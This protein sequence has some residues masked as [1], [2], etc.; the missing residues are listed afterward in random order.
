M[1]HIDLQAR[2]RQ[3]MIDAGFAPS[4]SDAAREQV[5]SLQSR[6]APTTETPDPRDL[7]SI[8][9]SS[10]DNED[11]KDFDQL[12]FAQMKDGGAL[13]I[14][15]AIADVD[16]CVPKGSPIDQ[17]AAAQTTSIYLGVATY[18]MLPLELSTDMTSLREDADRLAMVADLTIGSDGALKS[19]DVYPAL[20]RN[21]AHLD[22]DALGDWLDNGAPAPPAVANSPELTS[23]IQLQNKQSH[24]L[25]DMRHKS[26][27]LDFETIEANPVMTDGQVTDMTVSK[28][29]SAR[30][31]IENFMI[32][33]N[34]GINNFL[35]AKGFPCMQRVVKEPAR[36]P[37]IV[38][39][40]ESYGTQLP[41]QPDA[42]ALSTFLKSRRDADPI[43]FPDLSLTIV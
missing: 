16:V 7:R 35:Q 13:H 5:E 18:P 4:F 25:D 19:T 10:V 38:E 1:N 6:P 12:E 27:A 21:H 28:V 3:A 14:L 34:Q 31:L 42:R 36:W 11:T 29:N 17:F 37:K 23:Q 26:G 43:R 2:A 33:A 20:V 40:A 22:Y 8:L 41:A 39:V 24:I 15:V 30:E 32:A 9:W